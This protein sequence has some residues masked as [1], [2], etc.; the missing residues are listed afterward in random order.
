VDESFASA[1]WVLQTLF[2]FARTGADGVNIHTYAGSPYALFK[3]HDDHGDWSSV[4]YPE[5]YGM[6]MFAQA[7]PAGSRLLSTAGARRG[8]VQ[9]WATRAPGGGVRVVLIN[10]RPQARTLAVR[11]R[12]GDI[13]A[14]VER[15]LGPSLQ[16]RTGV[17]IGGQS[18]TATSATGVP[19]GQA[20]IEHV[21]RRHGAYRV[22]IPGASA[23]LLTIAPH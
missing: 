23:A 6:R 9:A 1:L 3:F 22:W 19:S 18:F 14:T 7:A 16:A 5:Y 10:A 21:A 13:G 8:R 20:E 2:A 15:L 17:T 4:A 11:V 12:G